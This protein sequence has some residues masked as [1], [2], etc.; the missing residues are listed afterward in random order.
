MAPTALSGILDRHPFRFTAETGCG[1]STIVLSHASE[2][3][4]AFAVEGENQTISE[5]RRQSE[6]RPQSVTFVE[7]LPEYRFRDE[8][9][10][11]LLDGRTH[12]RCHR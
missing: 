9:D 2:R 1:G 7:A 5:L 8:L 3:H 12:I 10:L 11:V 6:F 4:I